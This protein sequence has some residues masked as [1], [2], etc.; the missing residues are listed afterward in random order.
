MTDKYTPVDNRWYL[1]ALKEFLPDAR[2]SH[3]K[4]DED[5]IFGNLLLPDSIMDYGQDDDTDYGGMVSIS[6]CEIGKRKS[7]GTLASFVL[8]A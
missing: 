6:N 5:T 2:Y 8:S 7:H 3:W 4:G 1:E